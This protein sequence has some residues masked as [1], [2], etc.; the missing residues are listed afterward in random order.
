M[1]T[2]IRVALGVACVVAVG[3]AGWLVLLVFQGAAACAGSGFQATPMEVLEVAVINQAPFV[4][5]GFFLLFVGYLFGIQAVAKW[6]G[7]S[8]RTPVHLM[9][10]ATL[11]SATVVLIGTPFLFTG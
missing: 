10:A 2:A 1:N 7:F 6:R 4:A 11:A 9:M 5:L 3:G 8:R